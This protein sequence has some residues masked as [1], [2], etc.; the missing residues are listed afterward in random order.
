V[1]AYQNDTVQS[2]SVTFKELVIATK[3]DAQLYQILE[4]LQ[5]GKEI[6]KEYKYI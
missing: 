5:S 3:R 1:D 2:L 6:S 4:A